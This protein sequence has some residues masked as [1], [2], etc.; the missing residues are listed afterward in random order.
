MSAV[1]KAVEEAEYFIKKLEEAESKPSV[2]TYNLNAFLSRGRSITW[3]IKKQYSKCPN[4]SKWYYQKEKEMKADE[5]MSFFVQARNISVKEHSINPH[6]NLA[7]GDI[8]ITREEG[9]GDKCL[10]IPMEG[11]PYWVKK[12]EEG[13]EINV[14]THEFDSKVHRQY[15]FNEPKPPF[16]FRSLQAINLCRMYLDNLKE[17]AEEAIR[18]FEKK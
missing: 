8:K 1:T 3:I 4:F 18:L 16:T 6:F 15:F 7:V 9:E 11:T 13:E 2:Y 10:S 12:N 14:P 17:L 5:L